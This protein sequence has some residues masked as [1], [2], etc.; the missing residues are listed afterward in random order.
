MVSIPAASPRNLLEIQVLGP[1]PRCIESETLDPAIRVVRGLQVILLQADVWEPL[2]LVICW[3]WNFSG[4]RFE[5]KNQISHAIL[6]SEA[7]RVG[8]DEQR[9]CSDIC[10]D[11]TEFLALD[12]QCRLSIG[13]CCHVAFCVVKGTSTPA[14][15]PTKGSFQVH[16]GSQVFIPV[17]VLCSE[18]LCLGWILVILWSLLLV[19]FGLGG[20]FPGLRDQH[21][22]GGSSL[23][24]LQT[25]VGHV[26]ER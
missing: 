9:T 1:N 18:D 25:D 19:C 6:T 22:I 7:W 10:G 24:H 13:P 21:R 26:G 8:R 3:V 5:I 23:T 4:D 14:P 17:H 20:T 11:V 12:R 16:R 15:S 2:L